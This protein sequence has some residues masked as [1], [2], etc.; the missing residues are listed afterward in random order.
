MTIPYTKKTNIPLLGISGITRSG[1][2]MILNIVSTFREVEKSN[3][4]VTLEQ[5][6]YLF[7]TKNLDKKTAIYSYC[8]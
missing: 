4:N 1:K 6:Y 2:A 5:F 7:S 3:V 8:Y